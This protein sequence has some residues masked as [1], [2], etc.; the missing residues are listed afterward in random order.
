MRYQVLMTALLFSLCLLSGH[1]SE[2]YPT[3]YFLSPVTGPLRLSGTFGELRSNHFHSGI[4]I[5][6]RN[7]QI[8]EPILACAEGRVSRIKVS[9]TGYGKALYIDHPNGYTTVYAH[10]DEF[11]PAIEAYV[12]S[13]QYANAAFEVDLFPGPGELKVSRGQVIG[14]M[15]L[16]GS[17]F[18]PH[19]HF[20]MRDTRTEK[21]VNPLFFGLEVADDEPPRIHE[22]KIYSLNNRLVAGDELKPRIGRIGT[23]YH[24]HGDT[25]EVG[26]DKIGLG[27]KTY[28]LMS[29]V[30]N[31]NGVYAIRMLRDS[32]LSYSFRM[33]TFSFDETRYIN[34]HLDY[35][36][37]VSQRSYFNRLYLMPGNQLSAYEH[38]KG[39]G[40]I[41][42]PDSGTTEILIQVEDF[43]GNETSL[44]F[45]IKKGATKEEQVS[46]SYTYLLPYDEQSLIDTAGIR[47]FFPKGSLYEDLYLRYSATTDPSDGLYSAVHHVHDFKTPVHTDFQISIRPS[48][49]PE[50]RR[51]Q[52]FIAYCDHRNRTYNCGG[53]WQDGMLT[54]NAGKL[55][56]Y[57]IMVDDRPPVLT[58]HRFSSNLEGR[59]GFSFKVV[60]NVRSTK[61]VEGLRYRGRVDGE[62]ILLEY[63]AKNDL[64]SHTFTDR[65]GTGTH[66][67]ILEVWDAVGNLAT[68]TQSFTR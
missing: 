8:G 46:P 59:P 62:W 27:L 42:V 3:D 13:H 66:E 35:A 6:S 44:R 4:D 23:N 49:L 1:T 50:D 65:T 29:A 37:Q 36:E 61:D 20:E 34:A 52:A 45:W 15:G 39:S 43:A 60:D 31:M 7:G 14:T 56:D 18:G 19:L 16:T 25:L 33:E 21:P 55:G 5:K 26:H 63:D 24:L 17:T 58:P 38:E 30:P 47:L 57:S 64:L 51:H 12:D 54:T 11:D 48:G 9:A 28:D 32:Q 40:L 68:W 67:L 53:E 10:L 2:K 41:A 22:L